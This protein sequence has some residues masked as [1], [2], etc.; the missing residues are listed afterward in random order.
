MFKEQLNQFI[1]WQYEKFQKHLR[2]QILMNGNLYK[3][4]PI[5]IQQNRYLKVLN[6][7]RFVLY[8]FI[9]KFA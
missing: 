8:R 1:R 4:K 7:V 9:R 5:K 3:L 2:L 6:F